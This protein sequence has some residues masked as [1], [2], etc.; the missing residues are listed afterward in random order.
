MPGRRKMSNN[1]KAGHREGV[2]AFSGLVGSM[3][4][5]RKGTCRGELT[6]NGPFKRKVAA[7]R[8]HAVNDEECGLRRALAVCPLTQ[9]VRS[10]NAAQNEGSASYQKWRPGVAE[11]AKS[12][13]HNTTFPPGQSRPLRYGSRQITLRAVVASFARCCGSLPSLLLCS[14]ILHL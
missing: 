4:I 8:K 13:V 7:V 6:Q 5:C 9:R 10:K 2:T 1:T 12:S 11:L 3:R 14:E